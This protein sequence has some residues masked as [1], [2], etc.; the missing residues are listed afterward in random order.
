MIPKKPNTSIQGVFFRTDMVEE[1]NG[2]GD[3]SWIGAS[4]GLV[5]VAGVWA[6]VMVW[7]GTGFSLGAGAETGSRDV[8]GASVS[9]FSQACASGAQVKEDGFQFLSGSGEGSGAWA[10]ASWGL[11]VSRVV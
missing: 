2:A 4:F 10:G 11:G 1:I 3:L 8:S 6:L 5:G 7:T 9:F